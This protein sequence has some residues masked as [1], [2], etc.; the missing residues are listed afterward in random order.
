MS[1]LA[2]CSV[3]LLDDDESGHAAVLATMVEFAERIA[4]ESCDVYGC[5]DSVVAR[6]RRQAEFFD[7]LGGT[8]AQLEGCNEPPAARVV[9][10]IF[11]H[12]PLGAIGAAVARLD[13]RQHD[14]DQG[15]NRDRDF[16]VRRRTNSSMLRR[17]VYP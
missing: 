9:E 4:L 7:A 11:E 1:T 16:T 2:A 17:H 5:V 6:A 8:V 15:D 10:P 3:A 12:H 13:V 14:A